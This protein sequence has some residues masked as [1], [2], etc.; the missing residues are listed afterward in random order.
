MNFIVKYCSK[1]SLAQ[2]SSSLDVLSIVQ[3]TL[4]GTEL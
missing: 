3:I 4:F 1:N 2:V